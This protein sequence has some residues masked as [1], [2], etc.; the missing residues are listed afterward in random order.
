M[1]SVPLPQRLKAFT[2]LGRIFLRAAGEEVSLPS[3]D[4]ALVARLTTAMPLSRNANPWFDEENVRRALGALGSVM[5]EEKLEQWIARYPQL[6]Q[7]HPVRDV[8]VIM[9]GNI[10][11]VG[12]HDM[13]AVL[14]SGHRL[15]ART[16]SR[17]A[18]LHRL[19]GLIL[20]EL[21]PAFAPFL[22][23]T[24]E[25]P[26]R[27]DAVIATGSDNTARYF[28]YHYQKVPAII[29]RNRN[30]LAILD[31]NESDEELRGLANDI[32]WYYGL[33][34]RSVSKIF[35]PEGYNL[36]GRLFP[37]FRE[38]ASVNLLPAWQHNLSYQRSVLTMENI[39]FL[40]AGNLILT[41]DTAIASPIG[42]LYYEQYKNPGYVDN[43][44]ATY[45]DKIQ[46]I[47]ERTPSRNGSIPFGMSQFPGLWNY[48]DGIDTMEFLLTL[49]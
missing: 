43:Y 28:E 37:F 20:T 42:L 35:V 2:R 45:V 8:L 3:G 30:S 10:P 13:L 4:E 31:G 32:F 44:V 22:S 15:L 21:E 36:E 18:G 39:P 24:R 11:L 40:D 26:E 16:S 1:K 6:Q 49:R 47:V 23:F 33:G 48:A 38:H 19:A 7:E 25:R 12:F 17:D 34:C 27:V 41:E 14:L 46:C 5:T 29:R 9:A